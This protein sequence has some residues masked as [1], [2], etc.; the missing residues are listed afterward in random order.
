MR[1]QVGEGMKHQIVTLDLEYA[2]FGH[3]RHAWY[4]DSTACEASF[5]LTPNQPREILRSDRTQNYACTSSPELR[6]EDGRWAG[7]PFKL[8]VWNLV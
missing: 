6:R 7:P 1:D 2:L 5:I 4:V 8:G 3:G